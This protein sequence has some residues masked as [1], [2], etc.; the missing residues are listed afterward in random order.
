MIPSMIFVP[1]AGKMHKDIELLGTLYPQNAVIYFNFCQPLILK[2]L[3][4]LFSGMF[5]ANTSMSNLYLIFNG[6]WRLVIPLSL[7]SL[8]R[9]LLVRMPAETMWHG[10][11]KKLICPTDLIYSAVFPV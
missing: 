9:K 6:N 3:W 1:K 7:T 4:P 5:Y 8:A 11:P 10:I 2:S